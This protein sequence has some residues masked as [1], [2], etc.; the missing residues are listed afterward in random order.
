VATGK[1]A[2]A[3][4]EVT[5]PG[6]EGGGSGT[7]FCIDKSGLFITN[8]HVVDEAE[9]GKAEIRIV[10]EPGPSQK[11][12]SL[13]ARILRSD[14]RLDLD[15]ALLKVDPVPGLVLAPLELG[16]DDRL[17]E[18]MPVTTFGYPFGRALTFRRNG[19][20][21]ITVLESK[22]TS[23]K[24]D[25]GRLLKIQFDNQLNPGNSGGPVLG[26]DGRVVGVAQATVKGSA[27][28]FAI[29]VGLVQGFLKAPVI[30]FNPP[31]LAYKD[32]AKPL[33]WTIKVQP[34]TASAQLPDGLSV[35]VKIATD[36]TPPR[37]F[38][39][40]SMGSGTYR[41]TLT[42]VPPE[43]ETPVELRVLIYGTWIETSVP[44]RT[45]RVGRA[46]L[47]LS[48][49]QQLE[50]SNPPRVVTHKGEV[51]FGPILN[52][53]KAKARAGRRGKPVTVDLSQA[54]IIQ[55]GPSAAAKPLRAVEAVVELK[56]GNEVLAAKAKRLE[57]PDAPMLLV[58][59]ARGMGMLVQPPP[60]QVIRSHDPATENVKL[61]LGGFLNADG[62]TRGAGLSIR[63]PAV[64]MGDALLADGSGALTEV[65]R[66]LGHNANCPSLVVSPDGQRLLSGS[67]DRTMILWDRQTGRVIRRFNEKLGLIESVAISPEGRRGLSG[68]KDT[69]VRLWDLESG[70]LVRE[71]RGH[72][73]PVWCVAFSPDGR[74]AYSTS[75]GT[76]TQGDGRDS[77]IRVWDVETGR[78][79]RRLQ[80]HRGLVWS[81][82]VSPDGRRVLSGGND[83]A[84]ILWDAET[85]AAIRR[86]HTNRVG[87]VAFL[88][89]GRRA[90]SG[91]ELTIHLLDL[92]TGQE[93]H[94]FRGHKAGVTGVAVSPDGH[95]LLSSSNVGRE[96]LLWDIEARKLI[97]RLDCGDLNPNRGGFTPDG[98]HAVW[99]GSD[100]SVRVYRL[101]E[102]DAQKR[103]Q[104][105]PL[106]RTLDA[107]LSDLV[108]GGGGRYLILTL[109][110][111]RQIAIFD[112]NAADIVKRIDVPSDEVLVAAGAEKLILLYPKEGLFQ[113]WNLK[114]MTL[115][116]KAEKQ[117]IQ[118]RIHNIAMG[119]DSDGPI[120]AF[121][122]APQKNESVASGPARCSFI[123]S[124]TFRVLKIEPPRSGNPLGGT[125]TSEGSFRIYCQSG[126][127]RIHLRASPGGALFGSWCVSHGPSG[128]Q[129]IA[130]EGRSVRLGYQHESAGHVVP[131]ADGRTIFTGAGH[132]RDADGKLL[133]PANG[134][135]SSTES[136]IPSM[137]PNYYLAISGTG[138]AAGRPSGSVSAAVRLTSSGAEL[139]TARGLDEMADAVRNP[140]GGTDAMTIDKRFHFIPAV[141][142]LI[143]V[144]ASN[145][146]LVLRRLSL[147]E[148]IA[149]SGKPI[150]AVTSA[151]DLSARPG[152]R[153]THQ[154]QV[155][156][157]KGGA[158]FDLSHGPE[159]LSVSG[160]GSMRWQVPLNAE[161]K[162]YEAIVT[163]GDASGKQIF[164]TVR[165][166]VE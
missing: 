102:I 132:R 158:T 24:W 47:L 30:L 111:A 122:S 64:P 112:V 15:L 166:K 2:T 71:F 13:R 116:V 32:R 31:V 29:P 161:R 135:A 154:I 82:A 61:S 21:D 34:P 133:D 152:Q 26:P 14:E 63:P 118:G 127:D 148:G 57:F 125:W 9:G 162:E 142:L 92:G 16:R 115:E 51:V 43:S 37:T 150:L 56:R 128:V 12:Q 7:A 104:I 66:F 147:D 138:R 105:E 85:G 107:K 41:V 79:V 62:A 106:V 18:T 88:P 96:L 84:P 90:V 113:R 100:G 19:Y 70:S 44:D 48:D 145:D 119:T 98:H 6:A 35:S 144:P 94:C 38:D 89:D 27:I 22:I 93:L 165:I 5:A 39:A 91:G 139:V 160:D 23:L 72:T 65:A 78:E 95:W 49:L 159:G 53:P 77:A 157:S 97:D 117:P 54:N 163:I 36:V 81:V 146:R 110:D 149:H 28:N 99:T 126:S 130:I 73:E 33:T 134:Q 153:L 40:K 17:H 42:P 52:L 60:A 86:F 123:D 59:R 136:L 76:E 155:R 3:L 8:A 25:E 75:G 143:T 141:N 103:E 129:I 67:Q 156:S 137:D 1:K 10:L 151:S 131:G 80:G 74:L 68:G 4:V 69:I 55:V 46:S 58:D 109:K 108:V 45:L 101:P 11:R 121:W 140:V 120:L 83:A 87:S 20:P 124:M 114:T 50:A 164:H